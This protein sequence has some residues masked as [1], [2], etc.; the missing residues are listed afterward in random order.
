MSDDDKRRT[1]ELIQALAAQHT[2]IVVE[3]DMGFIRALLA[4]VLMLYQGVVFRSGS[5]DDLVR[6]SV[7]VDAYLGRRSHAAG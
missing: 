2:L 6:D 5:F 7:V 1:I 4:P 3:H